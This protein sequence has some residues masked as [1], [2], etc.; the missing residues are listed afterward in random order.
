M[1]RGIFTYTLLV[2][3]TAVVAAT[4]AVIVPGQAGV[5]RI[6]PLEVGT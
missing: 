5:W 1:F 6:P 4:V 2:V 3:L